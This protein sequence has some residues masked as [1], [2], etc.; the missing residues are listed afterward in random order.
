[1]P[2]PRQLAARRLLIGLGLLVALVAG[3]W[4]NSTRLNETERKLVGAWESVEEPTPGSV[5]TSAGMVLL[6]DR[7]QFMVVNAGQWESFP[8]P[9]AEWTASPGSMN[10]RVLPQEVKVTMMQQLK[11]LF[12]SLWT[13]RNHLE[14]ELTR[15]TE[16][17]IECAVA[18]GRK[19][20]YR[21]TSDPELLRLFDRLSAAEAP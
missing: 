13:R 6:A 20:T 14:V 11:Y 3:V 7:Q 9:T 1:M 15:L 10:F 8:A 12:E 19:V 5:S 4:W 17:E 2:F 16:D 21:R 18:D